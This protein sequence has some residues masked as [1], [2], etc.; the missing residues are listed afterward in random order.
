MTTE[1]FLQYL[2]SLGLFRWSITEN[3]SGMEAVLSS[4]T[5]PKLENFTQV[6]LN[7]D[8]TWWVRLSK[9]DYFNESITGG[10]FN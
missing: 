5:K 10:F 2:E 8:G 4:S 6:L 3:H 1:K 7:S 9:Q